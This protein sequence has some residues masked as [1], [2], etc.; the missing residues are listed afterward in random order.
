MAATYLT[1][2]PFP[3]FTVARL[4]IGQEKGFFLLS[5]EKPHQKGQNDANYEACHDG[6][7]EANWALRPIHVTRQSP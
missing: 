3:L 7:M 5:A 2:G 4:E 1:W 6:E